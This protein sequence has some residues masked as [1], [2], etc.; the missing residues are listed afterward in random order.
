MRKIKHVRNQ[1]KIH[2]SHKKGQQILSHSTDNMPNVRVVRRPNPKATRWNFKLDSMS[3]LD[4][5][6][7]QG[8]YEQSKHPV[9]YICYGA[10]Q[11]EIHGY[12]EFE[13]RTQVYL[14]QVKHI[15][16]DASQRATFAMAKGSK[17]QNVRNCAARGTFHEIKDDTT[18][19]SLEEMAEELRANGEAETAR[20]YGDDFWSQ[21]STIKNTS[22]RMKNI[23]AEELIKQQMMDIEL[24][25]WQKWVVAMLEFQGDRKILFV[26]DEVGGLGKTWLTKWYHVNLQAAVYTTTKR[27]DVAYAY[28]GESTV[29]FDLSRSQL[30]KLNYDT[31]ESIKN[32]MVFSTKYESRLKL[33]MPPRM[34]V[35]MN[36]RPEL[37]KN[38]SD[39]RLEM[40]WFKSDD[41]KR[42]VSYSFKERCHRPE[43]EIK[44]I[45]LNNM[46]DLMGTRVKK[47]FR[48]IF[49][50]ETT[51]E[52]E[53]SQ[54]DEPETTQRANLHDSQCLCEDCVFENNIPPNKETSQVQLSENS[55]SP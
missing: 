43:P 8:I 19:V 10:D 11:K 45:L 37:H 6:L 47:R 53:D 15:F 30:E 49:N 40:L 23:E 50:N 7:I 38:L 26:V 14:T 1:S 54:H 16:G 18:R 21:Y 33:Y 44:F 55:F 31:L 48:Q 39:D 9:R 24:R 51:Q 20:K 34:I 25:D 5:A 29:I 2:R 4:I 12:L 36:K 17:Q 41:G 27:G 28:N 22:A 42:V 52:P 46:E 35:F 13:K 32:G 3:E